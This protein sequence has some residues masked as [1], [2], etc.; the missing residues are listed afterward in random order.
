MNRSVCASTTTASWRCPTSAWFR[1]PGKP[2]KELAYTSRPR[3]EKEY[4]YHATVIIAVDRVSEKSRGR[5]YIY[6]SVGTGA[7]GDSVG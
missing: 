4:Y 3:F 7:T 2:A 1:R 5:V 6:G